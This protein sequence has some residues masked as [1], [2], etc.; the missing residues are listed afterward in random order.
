[1]DCSLPGL[2]VHWIFSIVDLNNVFSQSVSSLSRVQLFETPWTAA[3]QAFLSITNSQSVLKLNPLSR[4]CHPAISSFLIPFSSTLNLSQHQGLFQWVSSSHQVV[5][6][7]DLQLEHQSFQW[8]FRSDFLRMDWLDLLAVQGTLKSLLQHH[9]SKAP[10]LQH[11][12]FQFFC[13][14]FIFFIYKYLYIFIKYRA[15]W[16]SGFS[17]YEKPF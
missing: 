9:S 10:I 1:M 8:I 7:L 6:L 17:Y 11:Y 16:N 13:M 14:N 12:K 15:H 2:S 5:K 4:W 3:R